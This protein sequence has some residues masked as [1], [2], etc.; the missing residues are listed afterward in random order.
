M[1]IGIRTD[2]G[3]L[4]EKNED[5]VGFL[6]KDRVI[7]VADGV[8]GNNSGEVASLKA[9]DGVIR[10]I[11]RH[12]LEGLCSGEMIEAYFGM[13]LEEINQIVR[14]SSKQN[15]TYRGMATTIVIAYLTGDMLYVMNVG[16]S[17][18]YI[19]RAGELKQIT[20]DHTYVN[21]LI[22]DGLI[23]PEEAETHQNRNMI[24]R[25]IGA[26]YYVET[27]FFK[28]P[29]IPG[30]ILVMCTDG[31]YTEIDRDSMIQVLDSAE[32]MDAACG[33]LTEI[34]NRNGGVDNITIVAMKITED[35]IHE[36]IT[37]RTV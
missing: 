31:L 28:C 15:E 13:C 36:Q 6:K 12:P 14:L 35:D 9:V 37:E 26:D 19:F 32:S 5:A 22:K 8:G 30:D 27:D 11:E 24:T 29:V 2:A 21:K 17:R 33:E 16:D 34:A 4:R 23:T 10:F 18:A 20:E 3:R 1:D 7:I 25:A